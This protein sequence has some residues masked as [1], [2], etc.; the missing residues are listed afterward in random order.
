[1]AF[2]ETPRL[3]AENGADI[4][5]S[6]TQIRSEGIENWEIYLK[7]RVLENRIPVVACNTF[8]RISK[9]N[10]PGHSK[11]ISFVE[12]FISPSKLRIVEGPI[13]SSGFIFDEVDLFFPKKLR[14]LRFKEIIEK[15]AINVRKIDF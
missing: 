6:P 10:F 4:L 3:A 8:G 9:S 13:D 15:S 14:K 2:L 1:M 7:A 5:F 12:D 11:I